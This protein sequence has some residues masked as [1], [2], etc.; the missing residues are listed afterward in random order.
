M[1]FRSMVVVVAIEEDCSHLFQYLI[2]NV[3]SLPFTLITIVIH[4]II[5]II[6]LII[7]IIIIITI[8]IV[9]VTIIVHHVQQ[10]NEL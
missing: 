9:V 4:V 3:L 5:H 6:I 7:H 10:C 2:G 1:L 8:A